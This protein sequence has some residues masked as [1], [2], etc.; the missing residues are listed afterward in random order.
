MPSPKDFLRATIALFL[1]LSV[2]AGQVAATSPSAESGSKVWIGHY[3]EYE[4]FLRNAVVD[5]TVDMGAATHVFFKPG[6]LAESAALKS[7]VTKSE[8]AGYRLDRVLELDMV[9]PTVE[10]RYN[11]KMTGLQLWVLNCRELKEL[12]EQDLS[13]PDPVKWAYQLNRL[14]VFED[15][16]A[17]LDKKEGTPIV[18]PQWN[19][20][21]LDHSLA[22]TNTLALPYAIG[23]ELK[24]IDR[25][26]FDRIKT[27]DKA[28]VQRAIGD[29]VNADGLEALFV[30]RD[31]IVKAFEKLAEQEG[32][33]KVFTR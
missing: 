21:V 9:P 12:K 20:I 5:R 6:G 10:A 2:G 17:N 23:K 18:D 15:L 7:H 25:P 4:E 26:F 24:Q 16:A 14:Y 3:A 19:L 8:I 13:A 28:T 27:L 30:R 31:M 33:N 22:F 32:E 1:L 11:G 29:L